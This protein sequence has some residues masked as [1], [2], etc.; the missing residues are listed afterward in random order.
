M[1]DEALRNM[2]FSKN[3]AKI[4]ISLIELGPSIIGHICGKTKIHRRNVYDSLEMLKNKGFVSATIINNR[5]VFEAVNPQD[6]INIIEEKNKALIRSMNDL[7]SKR[8]I[9]KSTVHVYTGQAGRKIIFEE[10]LK[11]KDEQYVLGAH[12]PS[13][14]SKRFVDVYHH[15]RAQQKIRLKMLFSSNEK[16]AARLFQKYKLLQA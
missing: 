16:E 6:L 13:P 11:Q 5:N 3:E 8:K 7:L 12:M 9:S 15:R 10:K 14:Q 2:G 4:Y 1:N